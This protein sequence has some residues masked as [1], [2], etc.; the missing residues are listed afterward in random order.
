MYAIFI[1][2]LVFLPWLLAHIIC[3]QDHLIA[4][5]STSV[6]YANTCSEWIEAM[7]T[8]VNAQTMCSKCMPTV[9]TAPLCMKLLIDLAAP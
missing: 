1:D 6:M 5:L 8:I 7:D 3:C 2:F 4:A 9:I